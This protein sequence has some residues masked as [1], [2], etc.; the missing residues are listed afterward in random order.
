MTLAVDLAD[1]DLRL[2]DGELEPLAPHRLD[3]NRELELTATLHFPRV[4]PLGRQD[5]Q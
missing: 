1:H 4:G 3:Q 2:A 5:A